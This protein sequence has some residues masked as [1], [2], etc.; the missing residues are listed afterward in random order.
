[1]KYKKSD[2]VEHLAQTASLSKK[3]AEDVVE[4]TLSYITSLLKKGDELTLTG[5]GTFSQR[6]ERAAR[7]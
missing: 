3:Q 7:N 5:F 1:M 2:L 4:A 6:P